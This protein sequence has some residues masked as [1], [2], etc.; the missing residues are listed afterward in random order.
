MN[1]KG[2][3]I[4]MIVFVIIT[5]VIVMF[6][7]IWLYG[8]DLITTSLISID[9]PIGNGSVTVGSAAEDT[10]GQVNTGKQ[11]VLPIVGFALIFGM[12]LTI[13]ISNFLVKVHPVF[14]FVYL[15]ILVLAIVL[16]V[17]VSNAYETFLTGEVF[18]S[19]LQGMSAMTFILLN[20]PLWTTVIG[21]IG[22]A[23]LFA[24]ILRDR[25]LGGIT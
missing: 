8:F 13:F 6:L 17:F 5:F 11:R 12:M 25:E 18:S 20:L 24:G 9:A 14:F 19:T 3:V 2:S 16:S 10:F 7:G 22:M 15:G 1:K 23:I 21:F 4:D